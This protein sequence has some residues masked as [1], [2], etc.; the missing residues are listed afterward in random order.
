MCCSSCYCHINIF[1]YRQVFYIIVAAAI[2]TPATI[3]S[4]ITFSTVTVTI[5]LYIYIYT[6]VTVTVVAS[7]VDTT[8]YTTP[9]P[10]KVS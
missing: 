9:F 1:L 3:A 5:I 8:E 10:S 6:L 7:T 4:T 2:V